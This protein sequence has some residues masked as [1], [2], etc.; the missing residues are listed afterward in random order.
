MITHLRIIGGIAEAR[1]AGRTGLRIE[2]PLLMTKPATKPPPTRTK[3]RDNLR[4]PLALA[5][6]RRMDGLN[7]TARDFDLADLSPSICPLSLARNLAPPQYQSPRG[8]CKRE[9]V[10]PTPFTCVDYT[11]HSWNFF[12]YG[13]SKVNSLTP[14]LHRR[15]RLDAGTTRS[16]DPIPLGLTPLVSASI[17]Q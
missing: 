10:T 15:A 8:P 9:H 16:H 17:P 12:Q 4:D 3:G 2:V 11:S 7:E 1:G 5:R 6:R 14:H 13:T